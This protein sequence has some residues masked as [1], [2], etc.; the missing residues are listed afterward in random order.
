MTNNPKIVAKSLGENISAPFFKRLY[1]VIELNTYV[2]PYS[3]RRGFVAAR[4][5]VV[6]KAKT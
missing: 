5:S 3:E 4:S 2:I 6:I 1:R